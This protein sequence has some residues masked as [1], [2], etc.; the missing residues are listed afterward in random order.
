MS[1]K[2]KKRMNRYSIEDQM[3]R[4]NITREEAEDK[5]KELKSK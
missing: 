1:G 3:N 4:Y 5:I 2:D